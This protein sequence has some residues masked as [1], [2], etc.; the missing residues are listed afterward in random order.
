MALKVIKKTNFKTEKLLNISVDRDQHPIGNLILMYQIIKDTPLK[1]IKDQHLTMPL[2]I[3]S[4]KE[5]V[6]NSK[7]T[8]L[9][10]LKISK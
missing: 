3:M 5:S 1:E 10:G 6:C 4:L 8:F 2:S 7:I 9:N